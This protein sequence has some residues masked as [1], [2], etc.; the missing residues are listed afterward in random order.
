MTI[1]DIVSTLVFLWVLWR[2]WS[3]GQRIRDVEND[4][5]ELLENRR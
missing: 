1:W 3:L 2:M 4:I 5:D